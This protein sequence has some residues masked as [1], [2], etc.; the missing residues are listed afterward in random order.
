MT[1]SHPFQ[2]KTLKIMGERGS[3]LALAR[4][5]LVLLSA[6]FSLFFIVITIRAFDV[7]VLQGTMKASFSN[8]DEQS[9]V[10]RD[11]D[12]VRRSDIVD[13]NGVLL[14]TSLRVASLYADPKLIS[15][16]AGS[17]KGLVRIFPELVYG[18]VLQKLQSEGR[19]IWVRRNLTPDEQYRVLEIGDP[20]L[21][22]RYEDKRIYPEGALTSHIVG[23]TDVD[24]RGLGGIER[25][26]NNLL[27]TGE[28]APLELT[29][30]IR[31][32][33][34]L[35]RELKKAVSDFRAKGGAGLV[36]DVKSGEVLASVSYPD[37]DPHHPGHAAAENLFN[38][39]TLGVYELGSTFKIFST[40][41]LLD[42]KNVALGKKF[43]ATE[44]IKYGHFLIRDYHPQKRKL[45]IP[46]VFI[47]SSN[48]GSALIGEM[49]GT[50][51][52]KKFYADLGLLD[53]ANI[54]IGEVGKP[55]VPDPWRDINTLT[56]SYGHGIAVSPLQLITAVS[57]IV[58]EGY[59]VSPTFIKSSGPA[60]SVFQIVSPETSKKMRGL[61][62][63]VV[64]EGTGGNADVPGYLVG[65]KTGT[66][67]KSADG[68]YDR[69]KLISSFI[70]VFPMDAPRYAVFVMVDE[71]KGTRESFGY[72]T[73]GW[74]AAPA[75]GRVIAS[76][77]P[78]LG[79]V[80]EQG[81]IP[82]EPLKRYIAHEEEGSL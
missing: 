49:I 76:M 12:K 61:L 10:V 32:Q 64:T 23:Y 22:F 14:A 11:K 35:R 29:L 51:D 24:G 39:A 55:I 60:E 2:R 73:G 5:R 82:E 68:S 36:M 15:D 57:T 3:T 75:A 28:E 52:L 26:F 30:D 80:P 9:M 78:L 66:A 53:A 67:E 62:R 33:H 44:P 65:G 17:A 48:I 21:S 70:A 71:P 59:F 6:V 40:A 8:K 63:L 37:F 1:L 16:P 81:P 45:T 27:V 20:G 74:V 42:L 56:A 34:I 31:I 47:Y 7:M 43:D 69:K 79:M 46:E 77:A 54:E 58:N 50:E 19:F 38:R 25:A 13:R 18:E 72:A 41:A 4:G